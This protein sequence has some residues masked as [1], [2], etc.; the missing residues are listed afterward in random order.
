MRFPADADPVRIKKD[1]MRL[2]KA[3][4]S[5]DEAGR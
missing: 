4:N 3:S 5:W 2:L 1:L